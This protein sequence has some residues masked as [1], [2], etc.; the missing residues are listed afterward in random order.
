MTSD[1][2]LSE[3]RARIK[4]QFEGHDTAQHGEK[5]DQLWKDKVT[6]WDNES[7]NP[8][9][10]DI[11]NERE[12]LVSKKADGSRKKALVAGCGKG[13]DVLLLSAM[14]YDAY[15]LDI[16]QTGLQGAKDTEKEKDGKGLYEPKDG[17]E[18][19]KVTWIAGDFFKDDFLTIVEG[20]KRFDLIYDYTFGCALPPVLRPAWSKRY[21]E[22]LSPEGRLICLEFPSTKSPSIGGPPWAMPPRIYEGHLSRPGEVLPYTETCELEVEKLGAPHQNGLQ[23]TAHFHPKRTNRGGY[24]SDGKI[25]DW[26][27]V[28]TH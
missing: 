19:G 10:I 3:T 25:T 9:L 8:A 26:V 14:G 2:S 11:L 15:G 18:K 17:I 22:L 7:P 4:A 16:S 27:S 21:H 5:W 1:L 24:D 6:P 13:Y 23:R 12:D 28:W 20:E